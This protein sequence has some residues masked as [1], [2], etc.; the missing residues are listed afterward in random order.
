MRKFKIKVKCI[1]EL[2]FELGEEAYEDESITTEQI[3]EM[4]EDNVL[5]DPTYFDTWNN[6]TINVEVD[7]EEIK[8]D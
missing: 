7:V 8:D 6:S 5:S 3:A 2:T 1:Q 4:E